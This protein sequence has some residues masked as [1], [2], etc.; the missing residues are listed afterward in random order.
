MIQTTSISPGFEDEKVYT[1]DVCAEE[2]LTDKNLAMHKLNTHPSG[3]M[4]EKYICDRC[5]TGKRNS[6]K[7]K[8]SHKVFC[9]F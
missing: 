9:K 3:K 2:F 4:Q 1:C 8:R 7:V 5:D 6:E